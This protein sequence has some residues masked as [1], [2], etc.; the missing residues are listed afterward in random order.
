MSRMGVGKEGGGGGCSIWKQGS[1]KEKDK[2][3]RK[4]EKKR[5]EIKRLD[6]KVW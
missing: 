3:G 5:K 2:K 6:E 4:G 1:L